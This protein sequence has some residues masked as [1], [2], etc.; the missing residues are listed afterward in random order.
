MA[1][2]LSR[3]EKQVAIDKMIE[4]IGLS[5]YHRSY[6]REISGGM[7]QRVG[8]A[9]ALVSEPKMLCLDEAF[10]AL[11]VL[12]AET[13]RHEII[14]L[15]QK[16]VAN[17][18]SI[19]MVT[20]NIEEAVE[21]A[22]R[23]CILFPQSRPTGPHT[24]KQIAISARRQVAGIPTS[25]GYHSRDHH[26]FTLPDQPPEPPPA[27]GQLVSR[28]RRR[29]ESIPLVSVGQ[30]IGLISILYD[31]PELTN[32]YDIS[33]EIEKDF[34]ETIAI[35]KAAEI[36][37]LVDTPKNDVQLTPLGRRFHEASREERPKIF[38]EQ[39]YKLRLF[40]IILAYLEVSK[41]S[42]P[43]GFCRTLLT[44]CPTITRK[45]IPNYDCLGPFCENHGLQSRHKNRVRSKGRR[46]SDCLVTR[47]DIIERFLFLARRAPTSMNWGRVGNPEDLPS[48]LLRA[49]GLGEI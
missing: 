42:M 17:L 2:R 10:S 14:A 7:R 22:T 34:G 8:L 16:Q 43:N 27:P 19:F 46:R 36:L 45:S 11:D 9:R 13:L 5:N 15:W 40:H 39:I 49:V 4:L 25:G 38:S 37:E 31:E 33:D 48:H 29:M 24:G 30:I 20:H 6:P 23:I 32:I 26:L 28:A 1:K 12:T 18:K 35:V 47:E 21:M 41:K 44:H 3:S